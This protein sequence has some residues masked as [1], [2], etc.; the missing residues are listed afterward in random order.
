MAAAARPVAASGR[1][2]ACCVRSHSRSAA[3]PRLPVASSRR[4]LT[5]VAFRDDSRAAA[6]ASSAPTSP[7]YGG[8]HVALELPIT[9]YQLLQLSPST[10][11]AQAVR[12]ACEDLVKSTPPTTYSSDTLF[13]RAVFLKAAAECLTDKE[14]RRVYDQRL[15]EGRQRLRVAPGDLPGALVLLQEAGEH[16]LV[17]AYGGPWL[18]RN[19]LQPD[20]GDVAACLALAHCDRA[21]VK[22][23]S[24]NSAVLP[25]C[26]DL[27]AALA[28]LRRYGMAQQ[29]QAQISSALQVRLVVRRR[30]RGCTAARS[31]A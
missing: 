30:R 17:L 8:E 6:G 22:L 25:A 4:P 18:E 24:D 27:E 23:Q 3:V 13:S 1:L 2:A 29:L 16:A 7:P 31:A 9:H 28:L 19:G 12:R 11:S 26:E 10:A 14:T 15:R 21:G 5:V 20:A